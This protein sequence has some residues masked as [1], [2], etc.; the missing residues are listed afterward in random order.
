M[1]HILIVGA[2]NIIYDAAALLFFFPPELSM[3]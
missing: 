1:S 3:I 2:L